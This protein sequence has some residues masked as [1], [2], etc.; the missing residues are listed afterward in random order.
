MLKTYILNYQASI[1][2]SIKSSSSSLWIVSLITAP[3]VIYFLLLLFEK[4]IADLIMTMYPL[5]FGKGES[6]YRDYIY[7]ARVEVLWVGFFFLLSLLLALYTSKNV[8]DRHLKITSDAKVTY[9]VMLVACGYFLI[10][11]LITNYVLE[12]FPN[13]S[14]E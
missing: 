12:G 8:L 3:V 4:P 7:I 11:I 2:N 13:S 9:Y 6:Y 5:S 14:D 10:T 1:K